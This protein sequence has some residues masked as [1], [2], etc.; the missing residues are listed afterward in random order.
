MNDLFTMLLSAILPTVPAILLAT[1]GEIYA[2]RSGVA[3]LGVEG[4][5]ALG[6][7]AGFAVAHSSGNAWLGL[8]A[9]MLAGG[10]AALLHAFVAITLRAN[11]FVSGLALSLFGVGAAGVLGKRFE[12]QPLEAP[13]QEWY[14]LLLAVVLAGLLWFHLY[15]TKGGLILRSSGENPAAVDVLGIDVYRVRYA[16]VFFGGMMAGLAGA[17]LSLASQPAWT[18]NITG[19]IGWI[20]VALTIFAVW[21][22]LG[23][24]LGSLFFGSLYYLAF[25]LQGNPNIPSEF[26]RMA[27]Y[28]LVI[29]ALSIGNRS[30]GRGTAPE[31]LGLGYARGE[32]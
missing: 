23:A 6:A 30:R 12:G 22:P 26:L 29:V 19:G 13:L 27:P 7:L 14:F 11:Q 25:R 24:L 18:E 8:L 32:R 17:Y 20:A 21:N 9:A 15:K 31:A 10:L 4:M 16:A 5:M 3:N 2:E 28:L 1:L